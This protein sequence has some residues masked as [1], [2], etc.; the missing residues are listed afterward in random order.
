MKENLL[1]LKDLLNIETI[2]NK[3]YKYLNSIL[4]YAYLD[5][6]K[7]MDTVDK[8]NN[9]FSRTIKMKPIYVKRSTY[10]D[11]GVEN[12]DKDPKF[13]VGDHVRISKYKNIFPK[14]Y[15]TNWSEENF[16][17]KK[18]KNTVPWTQV[19]KDLNIL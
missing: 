16:V 12:N 8:C 2:K 13:G 19:I 4:K 10:I 15:T 17:I 3:I 9:T 6:L 11:F 7:D 18:V 5:K 1:L 14:D